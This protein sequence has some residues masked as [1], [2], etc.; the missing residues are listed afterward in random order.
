MIEV[1]VPFNVPSLKNSK[2]IVRM[3]NGRSGLTSSKAVKKYLKLFGIKSYRSRSS[4]RLG[5]LKERG[6]QLYKGKENLFAKFVEELKESIE[7]IEKPVLL[8]FHFVRDSKRKFDFVN[9][10][11]LPL[12]L[13]VTAGVLSEDDMDEVIPVPFKRDD[14][15]YTV[16]KTNAGMY[17]TLCTEPLPK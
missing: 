17:I 2:Q 4:E 16:D 12:D 15:F 10:V 6:F 1:F 7:Q 11:Q 3:G 13:M 14:K 9:A 5:V 8:G